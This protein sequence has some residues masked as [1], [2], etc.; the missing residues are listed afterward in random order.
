ATV[1]IDGD[2]GEVRGLMRAMI[3]Q[4]AVLQPPDQLLIVAVVSDRNRCHWDWLKW[5]PHNQHPTV[6]DAVGS[7]RM[8]Y[9]SPAEAQSALVGAGLAGV[10]VI[11]DLDE[12]A[13]AGVIAGATILEAGTGSDGT[14]LVIKRAGEIQAL[15]YPD[16]M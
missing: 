14:Q 5:L 12:R 10:V 16:Q 11:A 9:R 15:T 8:V 4:L 1:T 7:A 13:T 3:C 6:T 2:L